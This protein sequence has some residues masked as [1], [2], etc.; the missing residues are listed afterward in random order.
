MIIEEKNM[1]A[2]L[3]RYKPPAITA[4]K[5]LEISGFLVNNPWASGGA[6]L[7]LIRLTSRPVGLVK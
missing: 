3:W 6:K 4:R 5:L 2:D 1:P 7:M